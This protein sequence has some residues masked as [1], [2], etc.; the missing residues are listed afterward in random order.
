M[1]VVTMI[2]GPNGSGKSTLIARLRASNR[3][4]GHYLNADDNALTLSGTPEN[5]SR[6]AQEIVREGRRQAL[7]AGSDYCFETV[8]SHPSHIEHMQA[9][10]KAGFE[11]RLCFVATE[12]P[13]INRSRVANRVV[14]CGHDVPPDRI[15]ARYHRC[16]ALLPAAIQAC[17][18]CLIFDNSKPEAPL[19]LL[20]EVERAQLRYSDGNSP[21]DLPFWW[22]K[23]LIGQNADISIRLG[24]PIGLMPE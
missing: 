5:V 16:L 3:L 9:A 22:V 10:R 6:Q 19:R 24:M 20:A 23:I 15:E 8:M 4:P 13:V 12:G 1:P 18:H 17:H 11:T 7:S 21:V 14:H 2:A